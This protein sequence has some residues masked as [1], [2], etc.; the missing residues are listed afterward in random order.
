[1]DAAIDKPSA[2]AAGAF[3]VLV[4]M[5]SGS[6]LVEPRRELMLGLLDGHAVDVVDALAHF[7]IRP[8][9]RR[10]GKRRVEIAPGKSGQV[11]A[12]RVGRDTLRQVRHVGLGGGRGLVPLAR[13]EEH[14][15]ELQSRENLVCRL[16]L[17]KKK[18]RPTMM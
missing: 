17:E 8:Q 7:V 15:S 11:V 16:L 6:V 2:E 12:E 1:H 14:T 10:A 4:E 9:E 5:H 3:G 13:S 18:S